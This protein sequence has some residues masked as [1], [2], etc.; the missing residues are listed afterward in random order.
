[1]RYAL[2]K[3]STGEYIAGENW[4]RKRAVTDISEAKLYHRAGQ[5]K[6]IIT[7]WS[8]RGYHQWPEGELI[9]VPVQI[10]EVVA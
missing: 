8:K 5:A 4:W 10:V 2:K 1:M 3:Q 6:A 9:V 7:Q